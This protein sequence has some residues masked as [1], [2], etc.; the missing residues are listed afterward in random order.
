MTAEELKRWQEAP[1]GTW[2]AAMREALDRAGGSGRRHT[3]RAKRYPGMGWIYY[4]ALLNSGRDRLLTTWRSQ[5]EAAA[6][7]Q[8]AVSRR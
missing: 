6:S 5:Y 2:A 8:R 4:P 3:V 1:G 7:E